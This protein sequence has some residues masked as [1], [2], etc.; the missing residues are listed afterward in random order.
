MS[1]TVKTISE[2]PSLESSYSRL[3]NTKRQLNPAIRTK[4]LSYFM[5]PACYTRIL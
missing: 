5:S 3:L 1:Y 4:N 2:E